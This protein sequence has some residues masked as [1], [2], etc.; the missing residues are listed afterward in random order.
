HLV[1]D[2]TAHQK[3]ILERHHEATR[4]PAARTGTASP[5]HA[6]Q[7]DSTWLRAMRWRSIGPVTTRTSRVSRSSD[8]PAASSILRWQKRASIARMRTSPTW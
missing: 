8:R 3:P 5:V 6:Q 7:L 2:P 4:S 1:I